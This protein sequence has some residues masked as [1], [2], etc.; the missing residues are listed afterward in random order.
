MWERD[1]EPVNLQALLRIRSV[2]P[3]GIFLS[4]SLSNLES[5]IPPA[6]AKR[7]W[8]KK[9]LWLTRM[10]PARIAKLHIADLQTKYATQGLDEVELRAVWASL[11]EAFENDSSGSK[12]AWKK[13]IF[14]A[15]G[16]KRNKPLP[17]A[18]T[19]TIA[20]TTAGLSREVVLEFLDSVTRA[21]PY[22]Y[23]LM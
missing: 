2:V 6:I 13:N 21:D 19:D 10:A 15:L 4:C 3:S 5:C 9:C 14:Q 20:A 16:S 23:V 18:S 11:P 12:E 22:K 7:I 8:T 17:W 1:N